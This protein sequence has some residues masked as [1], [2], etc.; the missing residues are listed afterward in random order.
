MESIDLSQRAKF[1]LSGA[2]R[3]RYLNGQVSNDAGKASETQ[4]ISA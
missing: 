4:T 3:A 2:D 1:R